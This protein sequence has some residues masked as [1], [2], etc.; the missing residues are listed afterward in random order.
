MPDGTEPPAH[1]TPVVEFAVPTREETIR[2]ANRLHAEKDSAWHEVNGLHVS[3]DPSSAYRMTNRTDREY[4]R[5]HPARFL[6]LKNAWLVTA[7]WS[8]GDDRLPERS[9]RGEKDEGAPALPEPAL[10]LIVEREQVEH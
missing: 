7:T 2:L 10:R 9:F 4:T 3:Y 6:L 5:R 8:K 1:L